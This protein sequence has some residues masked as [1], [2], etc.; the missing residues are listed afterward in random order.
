MPAGVL[1]LSATE[2]VRALGELVAAAPGPDASGV[3]PLK[4][5][6]IA[7]ADDVAVGL[8]LTAAAARGLGV[9]APL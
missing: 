3:S 4:S 1:V 8:M 7:V 6:G 2:G 9:R 5:A